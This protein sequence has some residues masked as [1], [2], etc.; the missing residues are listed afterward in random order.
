MSSGAGVSPIASNI[1]QLSSVIKSTKSSSGKIISGVFEASC[2]MSS[3]SKITSV[4]GLLSRKFIK[5]DTNSSAIW[6][7]M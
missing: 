4:L 5:L 1:S 3:S 7:G 2:M 6:S